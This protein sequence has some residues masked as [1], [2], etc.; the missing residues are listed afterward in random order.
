MVAPAYFGSVRVS[1]MGWREWILTSVPCGVVT[2]GDVGLSNLSLVRIS[3]T[4]YTMVKSS[5]PIFVLGWAYL[6]GIERI[7]PQL[8]VVVLVIA[9]GEFLTVTGEIDFDQYGFALCLAASMLSGARWTLV[10]MK[11]QSMEPPLKSTIATMR[12]L[13]PSM[14][15]F[16]FFLSLVIEKPWVKLAGEDATKTATLLL[17]GFIGAFLAICM[18]LCEFY[19]IMKASAIILMIGG[20]AKEMVTILIGVLYFGDELNRVNLSGC[21]VVFLGVLLYK[22]SH[23]ID[24]QKQKY[25]VLRASDSDADDDVTG[26]GDSNGR[27]MPVAKPLSKYDKLPS[28]EDM[29]AELYSGDK[30]GIEGDGQLPRAAEGIELRKN[31]SKEETL[32]HSVHG[33]IGQIS[34]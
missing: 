15:S 11:L 33:L 8:L 23:Y 6:L 4:F 13:S 26:D 20:V 14:F 34:A 25:D 1:R 12:L 18:V 31:A 32:G 16:L 27:L 2:S 9:A 28:G 19:L 3:I 21:F 29:A 24:T 17:L 7:T 5:S 22:V 30:N 10:Q